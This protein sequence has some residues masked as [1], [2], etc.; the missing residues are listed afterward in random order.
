MEYRLPK[1]GDR[2]NIIEKRNY[3]NGKLTTGVV[4]RLLSNPAEV[5]PRGNKVELNDGTVGRTVSFVDEVGEQPFVDPGQR[6]EFAREVRSARNQR[7]DGP[8][9]NFN[10]RNDRRE[11]RFDRPNTALEPPVKISDLPGEDD[12]R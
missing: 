1:V 2:V 8:A 10:D 11:R 7:D 6:E 4:R 9:R 3:E 5:H 12:L